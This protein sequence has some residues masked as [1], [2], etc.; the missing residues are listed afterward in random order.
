LKNHQ[1]SPDE[2]Y[3]LKSQSRNSRVADS[4]SKKNKKGRKNG[5]KREEKKRKG[6]S[7]SI[8]IKIISYRAA[9]QD[10]GV[11]APHSSFCVENK[12]RA[13]SKRSPL[14]VHAM[15]D[16]ARALRNISSLKKTKEKDQQKKKIIGKERDVAVSLMPFGLA[17]SLRAI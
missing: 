12:K 14:S 1:R 4:R 17:G 6:E 2:G 16:A 13:E 11:P 9:S 10:A 5:R 8:G 15:L 3:A 7:F